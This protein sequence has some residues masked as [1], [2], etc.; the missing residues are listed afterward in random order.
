MMALTES[1]ISLQ[2]RYNILSLSKNENKF[3]DKNKT[4]Q[5]KMTKKKKKLP[6][7]RVEPDHRCV[8]STHC[9]TTANIEDLFN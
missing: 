1:A 4:K 8:K 5:Y 7:A 9:A 6:T 2:D 3:N